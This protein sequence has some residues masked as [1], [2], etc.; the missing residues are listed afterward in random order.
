MFKL[1]IINN[2]K[3][4]FFIFL[5]ALIIRLILGIVSYNK[6]VMQKFADDMGYYSFA[7]SI[8]KQ[9][10]LV[11]NSS[12]DQLTSIFGP[13]LPWIL[14]LILLL[15]GGWLTIFVI[16]SIIG[17]INCILIFFLGEMIFDKRLGLLASIW[18][19]IFMSYVR[20]IP[21][22]GK[23]IWMTFL[24]LLI[25]IFIWRLFKEEKKYIYYLIALS[26][27][28]TLLFHIDER[29]FAY[30]PLFLAFINFFDKSKLI[31]RIKKSFLF[32][33]LVVIFMLPWL[34]RN[35]IVFDNIVLLSVRTTSI[36]SKFI[37]YD[38][39]LIKYNHYGN[40]ELS[41]SQVDSVLSG[42]KT[43]F[44]PNDRIPPAQIA[45]MR[46]GIFPHRFSRFENYY[47]R[48]IDLWRPVKINSNYYM[49]GFSYM[50]PWSP[51]HNLA[52]GL[53]YGLL[54]PFF[55]LG[56]HKLFQQQKKMAIFL[57]SILGYHTFIHI[58]FI[59]YTRDRYRIPV[60]SI[61]IL[62]GIYGIITVYEYIKCKKGKRIL[63]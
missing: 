18:S 44:A 30:L 46:K 3:P 47:N 42:Q 51:R 2:K 8:I 25:I 13:G 16:N 29:Y 10:P 39:N 38:K 27:F 11:L 31:I 62:L 34:I 24:M 36:T 17:A 43:H 54:L 48:F 41:P 22:A 59:P 40:R 9:G 63:S 49:G 4:I 55:F 19:I 37:K 1:F 61:I 14:S 50:G 5:T 15:G 53:S 52:T 45:E 28:Y 33:L 56:L 12:F 32:F 6:N 20:Y 23:S 35:Y 7:E 57:F 58:L 60:E 21:S 26:F